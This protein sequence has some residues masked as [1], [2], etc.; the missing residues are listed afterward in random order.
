[1]SDTNALQVAPMFAINRD[2]D[3]EHQDQIDI[4]DPGQHNL[5]ESLHQ[6]LAMPSDNAFSAKM[7]LRKTITDHILQQA[8]GEL[9]KI[10]AN[11][12]S[13]DLREDAFSKT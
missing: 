9:G 11:P 10:K 1:M 4:E 13:F 3:D 6:E 7:R 5:E 12:M 2:Y 8:L